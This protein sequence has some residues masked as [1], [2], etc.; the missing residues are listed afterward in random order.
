LLDPDVQNSAVNL[1]GVLVLLVGLPDRLRQP[2]LRHPRDALVACRDDEILGALAS[3]NSHGQFRLLG[4][5]VE[6][7]QN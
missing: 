3:A 6:N 4:K 1:E 5:I 2:I 7:E